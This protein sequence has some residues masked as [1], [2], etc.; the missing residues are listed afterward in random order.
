MMR[1]GHGQIVKEVGIMAR[2]TPQLMEWLLI[3]PNWFGHWE[4]RRKGKLEIL[5][6]Q[7]KLINEEREGL[8][9]ENKLNIDWG[10]NLYTNK[11]QENDNAHSY[12]L[13][14]TFIN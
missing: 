10:Y 4:E 3:D 14:I 7:D 2:W 1:L 5:I 8:H 9:K 13:L 12:A 11:L 6:M